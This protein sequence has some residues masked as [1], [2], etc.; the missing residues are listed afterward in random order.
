MNAEFI[1]EKEV[2]CSLIFLAD[3]YS[4]SHDVLN[5]TCALWY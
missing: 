4:S 3:D 2:N 5:N 1:R